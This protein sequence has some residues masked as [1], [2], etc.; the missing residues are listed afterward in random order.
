MFLVQPVEIQ[1]AVFWTVCSFFMLVVDI[2]GLH[3]VL[4]DSNIRASIFEYLYLNLVYLKIEINSY[5]CIPHLVDVQCL[6]TF[7]DCDISML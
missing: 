6:F 5:F 2:S 4:A 7:G 1:N 3:I